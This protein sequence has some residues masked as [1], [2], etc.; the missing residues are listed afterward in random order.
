MDDENGRPCSAEDCH[1]LN[2]Q[3]SS[4]VRSNW[5]AADSSSY[6]FRPDAELSCGGDD[7]DSA[8]AAAAGSFVLLSSAAF[9][10]QR[11]REVRAIPTLQTKS[12]EAFFQ[13]TLVLLFPAILY[14]KAIC[15]RGR[16]DSHCPLC[17]VQGLQA[18]CLWD[19]SPYGPGPAQRDSDMPGEIRGSLILKISPCSMSCSTVDKE[20]SMCV[21]A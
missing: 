19:V 20:G 5:A 6:G 12:L 17:D 3:S 15:L 1:E 2:C 8:M 18:S 11:C 7:N 21:L 13:E 10:L 9:A 4:L 14:A 16:Q